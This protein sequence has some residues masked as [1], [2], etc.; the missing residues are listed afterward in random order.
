[1]YLITKNKEEKIGFT[2]KKNGMEWKVMATE[3]QQG[4]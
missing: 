4:K 2:M 3:R 1:M